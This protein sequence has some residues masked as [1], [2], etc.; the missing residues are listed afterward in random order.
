MQDAA[1]NT[2]DA[3]EVTT[4]KADAEENTEET[5]ADAEADDQKASVSGVGKIA[6]NSG[7]NNV[8]ITITAE[9]GM[10]RTYNIKIIF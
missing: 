8:E 10:V 3:S 4:K 6:L 9:N 1:K 5:P 2:Q 7:E